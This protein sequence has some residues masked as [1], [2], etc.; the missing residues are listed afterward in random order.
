MVNLWAS[1]WS[2]FD[3]P[4]TS[5]E[6]QG[7]E[8]CLPNVVQCVINT[9]QRIELLHRHPVQPSIVYPEAPQPILFGNKNCESCLLAV[10]WLYD[11]YHFQLFDS[12]VSCL[13][14]HQG[15]SMWVQKKS[16]ML[17]QGG[18]SGTPRPWWK[19]YLGKSQTEPCV[20]PAARQS[21]P[22]CY[23]ATPSV[24]FVPSRKIPPLLCSV[25][26]AGLGVVSLVFLPQLLQAAP[27]QQ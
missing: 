25:T 8:P 19:R 12:V 10:E 22:G 1:S 20:H 7:V 15:Q 16:L 27:L 17:R 9:W 6:V 3:L 4:V 5:L 14:L 18:G 26:R 2:Q 23:A 21:S 11:S 24:Q 13:S